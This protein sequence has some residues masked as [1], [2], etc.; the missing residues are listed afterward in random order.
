MRLNLTSKQGV[1]KP[2]ITS[3]PKSIKEELDRFADRNCVVALE[4]SYEAACEQCLKA[5]AL[6]HAKEM[7]LSKKEVETIHAIFNC[8]IGHHGFYSDRDKMI[9]IKK[10]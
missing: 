9:R 3:L 10:S 6:K 8:K 2:E 1:K 7:K 4:D 5:H